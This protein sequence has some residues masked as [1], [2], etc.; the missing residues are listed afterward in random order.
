M[1]KINRLRTDN[2]SARW[3]TWIQG[4]KSAGLTIR[5][6]DRSA[7]QADDVTKLFGDAILLDGLLP[8]LPRL[9]VSIS[10]RH[11]DVPIIVATEVDSFTI[12][13]EVLHDGAIYVSGPLSATEFVSAI[14]S[15]QRQQAVA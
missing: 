14:Q 7:L 1:K 10:A 15:E 11:P 3:Q 8:Q 6:I 13:Y 4:L 9:I 5:F 12:Y 2:P